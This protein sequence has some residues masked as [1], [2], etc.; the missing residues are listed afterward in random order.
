MAITH[1]P[2]ESLFK[3]AIM[4]QAWI[5]QASQEGQK[6]LPNPGLILPLIGPKAVLN[7]TICCYH[8]GPNEVVEVPVRNRLHV[9]INW[10]PLDLE[11]EISNNVDFLFAERQGLEGMVIFFSF[12]SEVLWPSSRPKRVRE[13][14]D[15]KN[16]LLVEFLALLLCHPCQQAEVVL[17]NRFLFTPRLKLAL[18]AMPV[19]DKIRRRF[20][21]DQSG[22][23]V[24]ELPH[25]PRQGGGIDFLRH[26]VVPVNAFSSGDLAPKRR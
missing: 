15:R 19:Q 12:S 7:E 16:A 21:G 8:P 9:Q 13:L 4:D 10:G 1:L 3:A 24:H 18:A 5:F 17:F 11:G 6:F 14:S 20:A 2:Q 25:L 26:M 23:I 22:S